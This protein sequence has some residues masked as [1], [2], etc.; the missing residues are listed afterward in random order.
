MH[1][2]S[3]FAK[4]IMKNRQTFKGIDTVK[5][6]CSLIRILT[7]MYIIIT[8]RRADAI[9]THERVCPESMKFAYEVKQK[10]VEVTEK[11]HGEYSRQSICRLIVH[12]IHRLAENL[13]SWLKIM[14]DVNRSASMV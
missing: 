1:S 13:L 3:C 10:T 11:C 2:R 12:I 7:K 5:V 14:Q 4:R 9:K 6:F 8:T